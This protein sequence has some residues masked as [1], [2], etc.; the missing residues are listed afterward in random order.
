M[1]NSRLQG[2][3]NVTLDGVAVTNW[4]SRCLPL[5]GDT[6][7]KVASLPVSASPGPATIF[8]GT[9]T[10]AGTP[11]DTYNAS[12]SFPPCGSHRA[13]YRQHHYHHATIL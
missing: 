7:V 5:T 10:V 8:A 2:V 1:T 9:L 11:A 12:T 4:E 3:K 13:S 6:V